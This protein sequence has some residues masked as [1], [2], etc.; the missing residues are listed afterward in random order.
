MP[1]PQDSGA[2]DSDAMY[3]TEVVALY[4]AVPDPDR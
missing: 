4:A 3:S 1:A 2:S